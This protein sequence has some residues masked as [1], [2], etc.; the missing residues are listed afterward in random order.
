MADLLPLIR[1]VLGELTK[2]RV[3]APELLKPLISKARSPAGQQQLPTHHHCTCCC[4]TLPHVAR[5]LAAGAVRSWS[6]AV[7]ALPP[8]CANS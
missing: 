8:A 4:S 2:G 1:A 7:A 5:S 6:R 3:P